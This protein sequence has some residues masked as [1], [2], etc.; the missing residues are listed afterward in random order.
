[1][2][3]YFCDVCNNEITYANVCSTGMVNS[4]LFN[5]DCEGNYCEI[6]I[7]LNGKHGTNEVC[8]NCVKEIVGGMTYK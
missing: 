3:K 8:I 2:I 5:T 7:S 4:P 6:K 1:M